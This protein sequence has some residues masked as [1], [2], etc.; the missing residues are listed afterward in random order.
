M[1]QRATLLTGIIMAGL[2]V[3]IGAFGAHAFKQILLQNARTDT[4]ELAVQYQFYHAFALL[5]NG[6]LMKQY[7]SPASRYAS[8]FFMIGIIFFSGSL[9]VLSLTGITTLGAITP[10]G[11]LLFILGWIFLFIAVSKRKAS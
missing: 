11:G 10:V 5:L 7:L 4:F 9:Y 2:G 3:A 6:F 8:L 1:N